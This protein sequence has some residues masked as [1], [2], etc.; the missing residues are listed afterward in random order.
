MVARIDSL[1]AIAPLFDAIVLDQWGVLHDGSAPYPGA[2]DALQALRQRGTRL[3]VLSNSGKRAAINSARIAD[4]GFAPDLFE[5]IMTSGEALWRDIH[6]GRIKERVFCPIEGRS[7]DAKVWAEGLDVNMTDDPARAGA[8]LLMGLP[9]QSKSRAKSVMETARAVDLPVY[10]TNPDRASPR[11]GGSIVI[12]PGALAHDYASAGGLVHFYGKPYAPVF[13]AVA[14]ALDAPPER[15]L[16]VG[17]SPEHD[18]AGGAAAG[19][20]TALVEGGLHAAELARAPTPLDAV[21]Q[22]CRAKN[23]PLPD[24][25]LPTLR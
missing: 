12:S 8:V 6:A 25:L 23:C 7:G 1:S 17:D 19:W 5:L 11:A 13:A 2:V 20:S 9:D 3:A 14:K 22:L 21:E 16:I 15:L 4:M 18:I 10:C 24:F